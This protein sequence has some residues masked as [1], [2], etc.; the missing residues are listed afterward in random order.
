MVARK[1][2]FI[3]LSNFSA[4]SGSEFY[5]IYGALIGSCPAQFTWLLARRDWLNVYLTEF[6][7][8]KLSAI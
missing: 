8:R 4:L 5:F 7:I 1:R 3:S 6:G 2:F